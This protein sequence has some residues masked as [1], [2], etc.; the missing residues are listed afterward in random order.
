MS[1]VKENQS[2]SYHEEVNPETGEI[3]KVVDSHTI[4]TQRIYKDQDEFIQIYLNDMAGL[5]N[6]STKSELQILCCLWKYS[7][8]PSD[9][10]NGN[11]VIVNSKVLADIEKVTGLQKQ[12]V[13]NTIS[14]LTKSEN[15][16]LIKDPTYRS[17]YYLNPVYFFKGS[18]KDR[19]KVMQVVLTYI[20]KD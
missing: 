1:I 12:S 9:D 15:H 4:S 3:Y 14:K 2:L 5:M 11:C 18:I 20:Q 6:I 16:L 8:Y 13:R 10:Q 7:T 17:T 19:P